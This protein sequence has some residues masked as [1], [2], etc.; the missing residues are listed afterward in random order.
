MG[1]ELKR[2]P[3]DFNWPLN[4]V[5]SGYLNPHWQ[6]HLSCTACNGYGSSPE[7]RR[8]HEQWYG[9]A[10]FQPEDR[11]STP[12]TPQTPAV[13]RFATRNVV[14]NPDFYCTQVEVSNRS[15]T[16]RLTLDEEQAIEMEAKR[17]CKLWNAQWSHHLNQRDVDAL[18]E[19]DRLWDFTRVARTPEQRLIVKRRV[20]SGRCN[21]WLPFSNGYHPTA[22]QVN[23]WAIL[24]AMGHDSCNAWIVVRVECERQGYP[25]TCDVC[26]GEGHS[27][28]SEEAR[29]AYENWKKEEPPTGDAYQIW[30]T[31][32]EGS[33]ISPPF[34][35]PNALAAWMAA[36]YP[37]DGTQE[38]WLKFIHGPGWS[39]SMVVEN[40]KVMS[41]VEAITE[42]EE[43][44]PPPMTLVVEAA[45]LGMA[46][47]NISRKRLRKWVRQRRKVAAKE[48]VRQQ[49]E[50][51]KED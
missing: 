32:S 24:C 44:E 22:E 33:P 36:T 27:W 28:P 8:L 3:V 13:R 23:T 4:E 43:S 6:L 5:W 38:Q 2:V 25:T 30:E 37:R 20:D 39:M 15:G 42:R 34:L 46:H 45:V 9:N 16:L 47:T 48:A 41:G 26:K 1:R 35:V 19:A 21:S 29:L 11:G 14:R 31:V 40:G 18:L 49:A 10:P 12:L 51:D 17:L 7:Y 50:L